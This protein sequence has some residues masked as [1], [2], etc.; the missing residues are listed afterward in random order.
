MKIKSSHTFCRLNTYI[1]NSLF[2]HSLDVVWSYRKWVYFTYVL[3]EGFKEKSWVCCG[4]PMKESNSGH[5]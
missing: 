2:E 3:W 1:L 5:I 4:S